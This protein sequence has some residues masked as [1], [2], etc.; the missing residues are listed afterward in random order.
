MYKLVA[1]SLLTLV[2]SFSCLSQVES[3]LP[4][5]LGNSKQFIEKDLKAKGGNITYGINDEG[6]AYIADQDWDG[7]VAYYF[8]DESICV[9]NYSV[10]RSEK[11]KKALVELKM[12]FAKNGEKINANTYLSNGLYYTFSNPETGAIGMLVSKDIK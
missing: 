12:H 6:L 9:A 3:A 2:V 7:V 8:N 5:K 1:T 11:G 4:W 10:I